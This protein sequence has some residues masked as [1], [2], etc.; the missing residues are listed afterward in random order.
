MMVTITAKT[1]S[2]NAAS[3]SAVAFSS[4]IALLGVSKA[5]SRKLACTIPTMNPQGFIILWSGERFLC[6][7]STTAATK[8]TSTL[9]RFS[10]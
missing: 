1:A 5:S 7:G 4:R 9:R 8:R 6:R 2:E 3:R 10:V